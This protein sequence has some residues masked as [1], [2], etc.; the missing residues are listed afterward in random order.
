MNLVGIALTLMLS[1]RIGFKK[2][3]KAVSVEGFTKYVLYFALRAHWVR[4]VLLQ[5]KQSN[6]AE[7]LTFKHANVY[8]IIELVI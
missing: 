5:A 6:L 4:A 3:K 2:L 7:A 1:S 8:L